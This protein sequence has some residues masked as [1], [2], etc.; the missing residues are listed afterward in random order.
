M[1]VII[2]SFNLNTSPKMSYGELECDIVMLQN[3]MLMICNKRF[4]NKKWHYLCQTLSISASIYIHIIYICI[5]IIYI[6][7]Y[8]IYICIYII[9]ISIYIIYISIYIIYI[10]IYIIYISIYII[11]ISIYIIYI[12][13]YT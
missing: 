10:Y 6:S 8:I 7:I 1:G 13:I 4:C 2:Y 9:Y 3:Y 11:Y 12:S 5:Y